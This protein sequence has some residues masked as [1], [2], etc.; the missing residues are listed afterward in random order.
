MFQPQSVWM[1]ALVHCINEELVVILQQTMLIRNGSSHYFLSS[2]RA[3]RSDRHESKTLSSLAFSQSLSSLDTELIVRSCTSPTYFQPF[4]SPFWLLATPWRSP[5]APT[6]HLF[7]SRPSIRQAPSSFNPSTLDLEASPLAK[8][9]T[10]P[11]RS[12]LAQS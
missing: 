2:Q 7:T 8:D 3:L 9:Q 1:C 5:P 11:V 12:C 4:L 10:L 6:H